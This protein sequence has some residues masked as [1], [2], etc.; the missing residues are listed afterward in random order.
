MLTVA[1]I[2]ESRNSRGQLMFLSACKTMTGGTANLDE[3]IALATAMQ[4]TGWQQVIATTWTVWAD[5]AADVTEQFYPPIVANKRLH[6]TDAAKALHNALRRL[7]AQNPFHPSI[8]APFVH[9]GI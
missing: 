6:A 5:A 8:W 1:D 3:I 7:R 4:Y 2:A 9:A